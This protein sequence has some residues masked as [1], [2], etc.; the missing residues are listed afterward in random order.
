MSTQPEIKAGQRW[1]GCSGGP[2]KDHV[3]IIFTD[4]RCVLISTEASPHCRHSLDKNWF[5]INYKLLPEPKTRPIT[6]DDILKMLS[7]NPTIYE[8]HIDFNDGLDSWEAL[9]C[10]VVWINEHIN[11]LSKH[12]FSHNP[13]T[14]NAEIVGP[15][16]EVME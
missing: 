11:E 16:I 9:R 3:K 1:V 5:S 12:Q 14:P 10:P 13:F 15:E 6:A 8:R 4:E 2:F 7:V